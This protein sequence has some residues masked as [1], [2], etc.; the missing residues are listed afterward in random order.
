MSD[1]VSPRPSK[2]EEIDM[3]IRGKT[4]INPFHEVIPGLTN[5]ACLVGS[6]FIPGTVE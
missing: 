1:A 5:D 4:L 2:W 6:V 3:P